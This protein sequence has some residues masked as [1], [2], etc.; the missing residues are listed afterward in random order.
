MLGS[1]F[2]GMR[3]KKGPSGFLGMRGKKMGPPQL[4]DTSNELF[5]PLDSFNDVWTLS[6]GKYQ[7]LE[8]LQ[9]A[10]DRPSGNEPQEDP[11][12]ENMVK[13]NLGKIN[14]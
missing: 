4:F 8:D 6:K 3:G 9:A 12:L 10:A 1:N 5:P 14:I 11:L 2:F 7:D 13:V